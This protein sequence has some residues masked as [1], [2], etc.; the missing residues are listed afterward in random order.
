MSIQV[1]SPAFAE[2]DRIPVKHTADG[3]DVSPELRWS[4]APPNTKSF[5]LVCED[6]DAPRGN[7]THWVLFNI[8]ADKTNLAEGVSKEKELPDGA[9]QGKNDFGKI[10][11]GGPSPPKGKPHRYFFKLYALDTKLDLPAGAT[12]QQVLDAIK[13]HVL[14]EG[15][16]MGLYGR[17]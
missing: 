14:A 6:P 7:W 10:G 15:Q 13:G 3:D 4:G 12:R 9:R 16:L 1:S 11:Y 5:A 2:G 8:P 17:S